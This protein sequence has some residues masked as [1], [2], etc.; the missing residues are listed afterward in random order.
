M[1]RTLKIGSLLFVLVSL[2]ALSQCVLISDYNYLSFEN[3][4]GVIVVE[5][6]LPDDGGLYM[7]PMPIRYKIDRPTYSISI[8][9]GRHKYIPSVLISALGNDGNML[10]IEGLSQSKCISFSEG[11]MP[12]GLEFEWTLPMYSIRPECRTSELSM[13]ES[14]LAFKVVEPNGTVHEE[15][16][17]FEVTRNGYNVTIDAI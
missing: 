10:E 6:A 15:R 14:Y 4:E 16:L 12:N 5:S 9:L 3:T 2:L 17:P 1:K 11:A 13:K 8:E 7:D